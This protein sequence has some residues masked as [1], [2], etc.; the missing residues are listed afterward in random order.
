MAIK[1][2]KAI[3]KKIYTILY[4]IWAC[5]YDWIYYWIYFDI[6]DNAQENRWTIFST[7]A[8]FQLLNDAIFV[9]FKKMFLVVIKIHQSREANKEGHSI[10]FMV[11]QLL[12]N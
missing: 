10:K 3:L 5:S 8:Y 9:L 6:K 11:P 4:E 2:R 12:I 7:M 1:S